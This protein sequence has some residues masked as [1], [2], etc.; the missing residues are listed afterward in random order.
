MKSDMKMML[1]VRLKLSNSR[2]G[3]NPFAHS[4]AIAL[5]GFCLFIFYANFIEYR[6]KKPLKDNPLSLI[7]GKVE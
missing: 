2:T 5:R 4:R 1:R 7:I 6:Q 3:D